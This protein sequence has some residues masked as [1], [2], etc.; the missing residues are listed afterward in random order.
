MKKLL[1]ALKMPTK[2]TKSYKKIAKKR[3]GIAYF[4]AVWIQKGMY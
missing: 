3:R 4:T 2:M 1:S